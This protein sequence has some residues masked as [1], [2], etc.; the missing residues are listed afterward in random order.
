MQHD[1]HPR[2]GIPDG[3]NTRVQEQHDVFK[4]GRSAERPQQSVGQLVAHRR[5]GGKQAAV[6]QRVHYGKRKII[7]GPG[8]RYRLHSLPV[9]GN[10]LLARVCPEITVVEIQHPIDTGVFQPLCHLHGAQQI[11]GA[12]AVGDAI[13]AVGVVPQPQPYQIHA[14]P[15]QNRN[16]I[17]FQ[18]V[19]IKFPAAVFYFRQRGQIHSFDKCIHTR[20]SLY[21]CSAVT[22]LA[23]VSSPSGKAAADSVSRCS[24]VD[25]IRKNPRNR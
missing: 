21:V 23:E 25:V 24:A 19:I 8:Q 13:F 18:T 2:C 9:L 10:D 11:V 14:V 15:L 3:L 22:A 5:D 7:D 20:T 4:I 6:C 16:G 12:C 17:I 1:L